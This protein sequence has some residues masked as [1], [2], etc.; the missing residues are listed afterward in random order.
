MLQQ[1]QGCEPESKKSGDHYQQ[2]HLIMEAR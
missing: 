1:Q 2:Q